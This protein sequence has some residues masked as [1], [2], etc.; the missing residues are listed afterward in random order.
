MMGTIGIGKSKFFER[1]FQQLQCISQWRF[2]F[3]VSFF[4]HWLSFGEESK[5][6]MYWEGNKG[7]CINNF[8]T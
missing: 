3:F 7:W 5:F 1:I 4:F 2:L 8:Y 6:L